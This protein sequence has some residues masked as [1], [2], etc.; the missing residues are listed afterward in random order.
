MMSPSQSPPGSV[1]S[2]LP[3]VAV[4]ERGAGH[5]VGSGVGA[6]LVVS[7][8]GVAGSVDAGD[9]DEGSGGTATG[10]V[11]LELSALDVELGT[12]L[13][14]LVEADVLDTDEVLAGR[15]LLGDDELEAVLLPRA[16]GAVLVGSTAAEAGLHDLEPVTGTVVGGDVGGGLGHVDEAGTGVLNGLAVEDLETDLVSGVDLVGLDVAGLGA[17]VAAELVGAD[18]VGEGRVVRVAVA[19]EVV[20]LATDNLVVDYQDVED[21]VGIDNGAESGEEES[22]DGLHVCDSSAK[23]ADTQGKRR[24]GS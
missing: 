21:V 12:V 14:A 13:E 6:P 15:H 7:D 4:P 17:D 24:E 18:D 8:T 20:V 11:D 23:R 22:L 9:L 5:D 1:A 19:A 16:P 2:L 3:L 10:A